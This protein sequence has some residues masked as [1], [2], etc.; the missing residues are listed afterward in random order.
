MTYDCC[1]VCASP[2]KLSFLCN[3]HNQALVY[4]KFESVREKSS[5]L[6]KKV[7]GRFN[8][9]PIAESKRFAV[10][11]FP[12]KTVNSTFQDPRIKLIEDGEALGVA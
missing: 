9:K 5:K 11:K 8:S 10:D 6:L 2:R 1:A 7:S 4:K 12:S 3:K